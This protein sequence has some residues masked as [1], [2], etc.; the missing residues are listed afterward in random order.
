MVSMGELRPSAMPGPSDIGHGARVM[1]M[2]EEVFYECTVS[3]VA[4][5]GAT[6][7]WDDGTQSFVALHDIRLLL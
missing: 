3:T 6:I 5:G 7:D 2:Y 1:A 4:A